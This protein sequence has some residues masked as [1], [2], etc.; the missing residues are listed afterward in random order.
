MGHVRR[1]RCVSALPVP[2]Q[3]SVLDK[4]EEIQQISGMASKEYR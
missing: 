1:S 4:M 3:F 2:L